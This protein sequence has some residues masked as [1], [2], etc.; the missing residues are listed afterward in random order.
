MNLP[1]NKPVIENISLESLEPKKL[2]ADLHKNKFTGYLLIITYKDFGF[3]DNIIFLEKGECVGSIYVNNLYNKEFLN[4]PAFELSFNSFNSSSGFLSIYGLSEEQLKLIL[5]FNEKI[6]Y[7]F[8]FKP[9][10]FS[11]LKFEYNPE[12]VKQHLKES[13]PVIVS[14]N[15]L[16]NKFNI[17]ELLRL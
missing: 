4:K 13:M 1:T 17:N 3:E 10:S 2:L 11:K 12:I 14:K 8:S 15:H 6:K 5:I 9:K 7:N 16:F